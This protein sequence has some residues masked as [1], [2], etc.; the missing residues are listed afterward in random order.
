MER[1]SQGE[2]KLSMIPGE[3]FRAFVPRALPPEP[4][5]VHDATLM[6]L[7]ARAHLALGRLD[8]L[9]TLLPDISLFLYLYVRKEA[10]LSSQ[11]EGTQSSLSDLLLFE[12]E[13]LPGVP[14]DDVREVSSYVA[15]LEHGIA[16]LESLPLSLRLLKEVH[17]I[18]LSQGRGSNKQPGEVR[19]SQN[20]IGGTRPGNAHFVPP[21]P[22]E[23][24]ACLS[25]LE[26][27]LHDLPERTPTLLKAALAHAQFE[28]I[29]P[30]LDG[31]GRLGRLLITLL[32]CSEGAMQ[33][34]L[35]YLSYYFRKHRAAY[36]EHLDRTRFLGDWEGW[37]QFFLEGVIAT[38]E[39]ASDS[40]RQVLLL[41]ESDR[42][43]LEA[44]GAPASVLRV[45]PAFQRHPFRRVPATAEELGLT[46]QTVRGAFNLMVEQ[47]IL[48]EVSG[49]KRDRLW[50]YSAY[51]TLLEHGVERP[52]LS[53]EETR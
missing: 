25:D 39:Q 28:T 15:A 53:H 26:R 16:R 17:E 50:A 52:A 51:L 2:W 48:R 45:Y 19:T 20:W 43:R 31:N 37:V 22:H 11:I 1:G 8:G 3:S 40:A 4:A 32:L 27:F 24:G 14:L 30:F 18:L 21:P 10:V 23:L 6:D 46:P 42:Q 49:K 36:Y 41:F 12:S 5:L 13:E 35:L 34:P 44:V 7:L 38:A 33:K 29:H 9:S 47:G